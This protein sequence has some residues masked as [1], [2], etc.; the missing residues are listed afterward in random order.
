MDAF[1]V[2]DLL[3]E[4]VFV[5]VV[6]GGFF[7]LTLIRGR[8]FVVNCIVGLYFAFFLSLQFPYY[9]AILS[10]IDSTRA[11]SM[12]LIILFLLFT[13]LSTWLFA[14]LMPREWKEKPFEGFILKFLLALG[15]TVLVLVYSYQVLPVTEFI[16][17]GTPLQQLFGNSEYFFWWLVAPLVILFFA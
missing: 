7:L 14:R 2:L 11:Q 15:A 3:K 8:Q 13:A 1:N 4:F 9:D 6:F 10:G 5:I 12:T 17:P 16:N